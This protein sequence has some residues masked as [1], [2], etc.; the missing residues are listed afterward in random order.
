MCKNPNQWE[1]FLAH[2]VLTDVPP[3][4]RRSISLNINNIF[5]VTYNATRQMDRFEPLGFEDRYFKH[6]VAK[7]F[8]RDAITMEYVFADEFKLKE[9]KFRRADAAIVEQVSDEQ[10]A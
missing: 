2:N 1:A 5:K 10:G 6:T 8:Q 7:K 4:Q 3:H 9:D